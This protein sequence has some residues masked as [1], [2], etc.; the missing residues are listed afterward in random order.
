MTPNPLLKHLGLGPT[1]RAVIIHT[2][3]IGASESTVTAARELWRAGIITSS[4]A[5][6]PCPWFPAVAALCREDPAIDMGVHVTLTSEWDNLRW[7]PLSTNDPVSGLLD[8]AGYFPRRSEELQAQARP[9]SVAIEIQSQIERALAAGIDVTHIDSHMGSIWHPALLPAYIEAALRAAIPATLPR[10]S[11]DRMVHEWGIDREQAAELARLV[12]TAEDQG[13]PLLDHET[14]MPL[15]PSEDRLAH[16]CATYDA[17]PPGITHFFIHPSTDTPEA[18]AAYP[19]LA[20]RIGDYRTHLD[21]RV[22]EHLERSG[23]QTLS[24]RLLRDHM[25]GRG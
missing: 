22:R 14:G 19:D 23:I 11:E 17:L 16:L 9:E 25:R 21:Q 10:Y 24:Y 5:M 3:D 15:D 20:A 8:S 1:D 12:V 4:T 13:L 2:D 7:G 6:V 18:R